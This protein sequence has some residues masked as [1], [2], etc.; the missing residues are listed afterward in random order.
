VAGIGQQTQATI[1]TGGIMKFGIMYFLVVLV[2]VMWLPGCTNNKQLTTEAAQRAVDG[3]VA[4]MAEPWQL[5]PNASAK[6]LG[7][8]ENKQE[9]IATADIIFSHFGFQCTEPSYFQMKVN[10]N[11]G[12]G[13]AAFKHYTDGRWV[14]TELGPENGRLM[15]CGGIWQG[16]VDVK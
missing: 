14:L 8:T 5:E 3:A 7:V 4:Q 16:T 15:Q 9:N 2:P 6:V 10:Q 11:W 13:K 12:S 1:S